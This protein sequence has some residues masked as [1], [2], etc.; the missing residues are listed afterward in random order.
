MVSLVAPNST[1]RPVNPFVA[2]CSLRIQPQ[3]PAAITAVMMYLCFLA[4]DYR[5]SLAAV[6]KQ[7]SSQCHVCQGSRVQPAGPM[8]AVNRNILELVATTGST[9]NLVHELKSGHRNSLCM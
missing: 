3:L 8:Y 2:I 4:Q 9:I 7:V 5:A 1:G 6:M